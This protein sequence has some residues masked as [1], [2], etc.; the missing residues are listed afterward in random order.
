MICSPTFEE[1]IWKKR[2]N[3]NHTNSLKEKSSKQLENDLHMAKTYHMVVPAPNT[4]D[5]GDALL[6]RCLCHH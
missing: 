1:T 5:H 2:R 3:D 6:S 4:T